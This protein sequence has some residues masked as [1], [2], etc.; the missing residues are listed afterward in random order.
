[1][2]HLAV[3]ALQ[4]LKFWMDSFYV[5]HKWLLA[6]ETVSPAMT[7]DL[8]L[9]LQVYSTVKLAIIWIIFTCG[10]NTTQEG[11][12][13]HVPFPP[14]PGQY[15]KGQG[16]TGRSHFCSWGGGILVGHRSTIFN[17]QSCCN[18]LLWAWTKRRYLACN[19]LASSSVLN[20][21]SLVKWV[22]SSIQIIFH[23]YCM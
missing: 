22:V 23:L 17:C 9:Y 13:C 18:S 5:W 6:W 12:M 4:H 1:M 21:S 19:I 3:S 14:F 20:A 16:H 2:A 10:P 8:D 15:V 11:T 7:F